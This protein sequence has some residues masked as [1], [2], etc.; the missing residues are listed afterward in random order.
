MTSEPLFLTL[1][2]VLE[3]HQDQVR[4]YGGVIG[5][6][7]IGLLQSALAIPQA[8]SGG[9]YYHTDLFEMAAAY[10]FHIV[11]NHPSIDGNK[12]TGAAAALVLL[13]I[14]GVDVLISNEKLVNTVLTVAAGRLQRSSVAEILRRHARRRKQR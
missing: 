2:E 4:R 5:V 9:Q 14:N 8:G 13:D 7:D 3:I 6:R 12:R 10:L 11:K 1:A